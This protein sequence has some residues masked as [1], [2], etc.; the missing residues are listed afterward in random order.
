MHQRSPA[1]VLSM[2]SLLL[3][4]PDTQGTIAKFDTGRVSKIRSA[5]SR[6]NF[7]D[8]IGDNV[9]VQGVCNI[10]TLDD[11]SQ[12][13]F[14]EYFQVLQRGDIISIEFLICV[15]SSA[16][17]MHRADGSSVQNQFR[18]AFYQSR[19]TSCP[20]IPMFP[21]ST[22]RY[23]GSRNSC[24]EAACRLSC[25]RSSCQLY[26]SKVKN[27]SRNPTVSAR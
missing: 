16:N 17:K 20:I 9:R 19:K 1:V 4:L 21:P 23:P 26:Q 5:G 11:V 25:Q 10:R 6:L 7:I 15:G 2:V 24:D 13:A 12:D 3:L 22:K 18:G 27:H 8:I 14:K